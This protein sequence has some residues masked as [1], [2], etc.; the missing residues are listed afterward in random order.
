[1]TIREAL[2]EGA[3]A[4]EEAGCP[5]PAVDAEW[6]LAHVLGLSRTELHTKGGEPSEAEQLTPCRDEGYE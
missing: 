5:S 4:L 1:M 6:L 3:A 2:A